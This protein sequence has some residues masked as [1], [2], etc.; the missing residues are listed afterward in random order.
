MGKVSASVA[1]G[2]KSVLY[3]LLNGR[4]GLLTDGGDDM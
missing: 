4:V 1:E 2:R 3:G